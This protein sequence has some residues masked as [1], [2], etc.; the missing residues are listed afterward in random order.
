MA[1]QLKLDLRASEK[2]RELGSGLRATSGS[3]LGGFGGDIDGPFGA[4]DN[5]AYEGASATTPDLAGYEPFNFSGQSALTFARDR[6]A[7]RLHQLVRDDGWASAAV[8]KH[9]DSVIGAG[10]RLHATPNGRRLGLNDDQVQ[11]FVA[12]IEAAWRDYS[13]DIECVDAGQRLNFGMI[14]ALGFRHWLLDGDALSLSLWL[15]GRG[16]WSTAIQMIDPDRLSNQYLRMDT[17]EQKHGVEL[18]SYGE[19][20]AYW[21][22]SAHPGDIGVLG[23]YPWRWDR[24]EKKYPNGRMK[25]VHAFMQKRAGQVSGEPPLAPILRKI[26]MV[27]KY[28]SAELQ[29]AVLNTL[30][31]MFVRS[32]SDPEQVAAS[33]CDYDNQEL[34]PLQQARLG[35]Y[36]NHGLK[37]PNVQLKFLF[38]DDQIE[39]IK[40]EHPN[41]NFEPFLKSALRNVATVAGITTEALTGDYSDTNY[42]GA[43]SGILEAWKGFQSGRHSF[44]SVFANHHYA[45]WLEEA[46]EKGLVKYP[47]GA[48]RFREARQAF[49]G[50]EWIGPG[51]GMIDQAKEEQASA[52]RLTVGKSTYAEEC[53]LDGKDWREVFAQRARERKEM[54][55]L[56]L[57]LDAFEAT[58][59]KGVK[60]A[61]DSAEAPERREEA[62]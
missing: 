56:G 46:L 47:A 18:G 48:P 4:F 13:K 8:T 14:L 54:S 44:A 16:E 2:G 28:D 52:M 55:R 58:V 38:P 40:P 33:F 51:M 50:C 49:S 23:A 7:A 26:A 20:K 39:S 25:V 17:V 6:L 22:R 11:E 15:E 53:S 42:S 60:P 45:N 1:Q 5:L 32:P 59:P 57:P 41:A 43:R 62:A 37:I 36:K 19:P 12:D 21:I 9:L 34:G 35:F 27:K 24:V 31:A 30:L 3:A 29:A 10:W 61:A